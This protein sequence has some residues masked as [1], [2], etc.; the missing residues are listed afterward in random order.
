[1]FGNFISELFK[2]EGC[3]GEIHPRFFNSPLFG[4]VQRMKLNP[5]WL[6][7]PK[8]TKKGLVRPSSSCK[9]VFIDSFGGVLQHGIFE[10]PIT[11]NPYKK[12]ASP[13][14][15]LIACGNYNFMF[16]LV[17][18]GLV[19]RNFSKKFFDEKMLAQEMGSVTCFDKK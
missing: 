13:D 14:I 15:I 7:C 19:V 2:N 11:L 17:V 6:K 3:P 10:A 8:I 5:K 4:N 9:S 16:N 1:M 18:I 12:S